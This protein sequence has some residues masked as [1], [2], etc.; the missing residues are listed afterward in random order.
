MECNQSNIQRDI[1]KQNTLI[2]NQEE[3]KVN[4]ISFRFNKQEKM[5]KVNKMLDIEI[6]H[7]IPLQGKIFCSGSERK[8]GQKAACHLLQG[9]PQVRR[10]PLSEATFSQSSLHLVTEESG[11]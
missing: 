7:Q 11:V 10:A 2:I 4:D 9:P 1:Y 6:L 8:C 3:L 5:H